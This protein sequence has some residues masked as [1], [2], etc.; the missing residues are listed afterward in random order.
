MNIVVSNNIRITGAPGPVIVQITNDLTIDNPEYKKR[1]MRRQP[2]WGCPSKL[3]LYTYDGQA[4]VVPNGYMDSLAKA[5]DLST[6]HIEYKRCMGMRRD[7]GPWNDRYA[8]RG[9]QREAVN[10]VVGRHRDHGCIVVPAAGGKTLIGLRIVY[11]RRVTA[12]WVTHTLDLAKQAAERAKLYMPDVGDVGMFGNGAHDWGSGKLIVATLQTLSANPQLVEQ[13][14][15][16]VGTVIVDECHHMPAASFMD[17]IGKLNAASVVGLTATPERKDGLEF[18]MYMGIGP[19]LYEMARQ[20]LYDAGNLIKPEIKFVYT[21]FAYEQ[22]SLRNKINSVDAG[23]EQLDYRE[24]LDKL[25]A[26]EPRLQLIAETVAQQEGYQ[27]V[28]ADSIE[29]CHR[30]QEEILKR[31]PHSTRV[32]VV[33]GPLQRYGWRVTSSENMAKQLMESGEA[34][35]YKYDKRVRRW[36]VKTPNYNDLDYERWNITPTTRKSIMQEA[37]AGHI[38]ILIATGQLV[39]EGLDFPFLQHGHLTTPKRGDAHGGKNGVS[40][41]QAIGRIMRADPRNPDKKA[42]WWDYVDYGVG[43]LKA[44][45]NSRR[46]VYTRLG[47]KC[48][49]KEKRSKEDIAALL[50]GLKY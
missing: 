11:E 9:Y 46:K 15:T 17:T 18:Y 29:Y 8:P 22:A 36:K 23:G 43:V 42:V 20:A 34:V 47:L 37:A 39:Q 41:E 3:T 14:N 44:Q 24:L 6:S 7:F 31:V 32:A 26:D 28:I 5:C 16:L 21:K 48:P 45:Y 25:I 4:L 40:V 38:K 49:N 13:L 19:K 1:K 35:E 27:I 12:L 30:L 33:H 50:E 2:V 10:E